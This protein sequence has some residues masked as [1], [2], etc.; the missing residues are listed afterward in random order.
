[1]KKLSVLA[2]FVLLLLPFPSQGQALIALVFGKSLETDNF[3]LG[4]F[5]AEQSSIINGAGAQDL[6]LGLAVGAY[7]DVKLGHTNRWIFQNYMVFKAPKGGRGLS[8]DGNALIDDRAILAATDNIKRDLTYFEITPL[9]RYCVTPSWSLGVG[10]F[11][12]FRL[13][14]KDYYDRQGDSGDFSYTVKVNS[15]INTVD[16]GYAVDLQCRLAR[17]RG[18]QL[19]ARYQQSL[20][21]VY[22]D[23]GTDKNMV[24]Q[25]GV[26]IPIVGK[27]RADIEK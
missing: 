17:G 18:I 2:L 25:V 23:N 27:K 13:V 9:M 5:L 19:N 20:T 24:F 22:H 14:A 8:V 10:P 16:A 15:K 3:K 12:G 26:G 4:L 6:H 7:T 21:N 1:M 11:V